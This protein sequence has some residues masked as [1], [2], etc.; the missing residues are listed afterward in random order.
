M[1]HSLFYSRRLGRRVLAWFGAALVCVSLPGGC[2]SPSGAGSLS[3][4]EGQ[5]TASS[6]NKPAFTAPGHLQDYEGAAH[7]FPALRDLQGHTLADGEF[8]QSLENDRLFVTIRYQFGDQRLIEEKAV[9]RQ[10]PVLNQ[11]QWDWR[12]LRHGRLYRHFT[13]DFQSGTARSEKWD[14][15]GPGRWSRQVK[16]ER[17]RTFA[18][19]GF[20]L[21][22]K[23]FREQLIRGE[24]IQLKAVGFLPKPRMATVEIS[25]GGLDQMRMAG[26]ARKGDRFV[27]HTKIP[28]V[29]RPFIQVPETRIWLINPRPAGFLRWERALAE[30]GDP[31][32]RVDLLPGVESGPAEPAT[33]A[34]ASQG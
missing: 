21:A 8:I 11:E 26:A 17:G 22:I 33:G 34:L 15:K 4:F 29:A 14:E 18:G 32:I 28:L 25:Y 31:V 2:R 20:T 1:K 10:K 5:A 9:F 30:P 27:I 19:F 23:A 24:K 7:A 3:T 16:I 6:S 13:V 12:E